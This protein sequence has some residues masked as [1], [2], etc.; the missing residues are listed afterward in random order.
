MVCID[1]E[2]LECLAESAQA[3][4]VAPSQ[5]Y[6][7]NLATRR[8]PLVEG[9]FCSQ[10]SRQVLAP[11]GACTPCNLNTCAFNPSYFEGGNC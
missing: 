3:L 4:R 8:G 6:L 11:N 7:L 10:K 2:L 9:I 5:K 1:Q